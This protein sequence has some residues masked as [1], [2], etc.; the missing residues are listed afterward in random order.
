MIEIILE[1]LGGHWKWLGIL[2]A[3]LPYLHPQIRSGTASY[4][5]RL[6]IAIPIYLSGVWCMLARAIV[7]RLDA[8]KY[9]RNYSYRDEAGALHVRGII[10]EEYY[11]GEI[12][13]AEPYTV[14]R[15]C[16]FSNCELNLGYC[17]MLE[18]CSIHKIKG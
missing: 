2:L 16:A 9:G 10:E 3:A 11:A 15:R 4:F 7:S 5:G 1:Y 8:G 13:F 17:A 12:I 14:F 6:R 18:E